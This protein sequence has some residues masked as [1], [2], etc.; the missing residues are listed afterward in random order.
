MWVCELLSVDTST[1][2]IQKRS[3]DDSVNLKKLMYISDDETDFRTVISDV[4]CVLAWFA[5][6]QINICSN[7]EQ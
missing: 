6:T 4:I 2:I 1:F 3:Q 5:L 7:Q